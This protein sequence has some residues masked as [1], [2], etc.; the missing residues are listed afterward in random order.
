MKN[1]KIIKIIAF[2]ILSILLIV[3]AS[4]NKINEKE[5]TIIDDIVLGKPS[6][7]FFEYLDSLGIPN[8]VFFIKP[9]FNSDDGSLLDNRIKLY[10]TNQFNYANYAC[11]NSCHLGVFYPIANS[12]G[13]IVRLDVIIINSMPAYYIENGEFSLID[14]KNTN[15]SINQSVFVTICSEIRCKLEAKYGTPKD[16]QNQSNLCY[17]FSK[18]AVEG[19]EV[20]PNEQLVLG[21]NV[22]YEWETEYMYINFYSGIY[23]K[24]AQ[25]NKEEKRYVFGNKLNLST[26]PCYFSPYIS[27][28]LKNET[29]KKL[30]LDKDKI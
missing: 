5:I 18:N 4:C 2:S 25:F 27:Y 22:R 23:S 19:F 10:Y 13:N 16:I 6:K 11:D 15:N 26:S 29:I 28:Q 17:I 14:K 24:Y 1:Y 20:D 8:D 21:E 7:I 12:S 9:F 3:C 30:G